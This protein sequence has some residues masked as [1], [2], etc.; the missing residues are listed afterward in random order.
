MEKNSTEAPFSSVNPRIKEIERGD[1]YALLAVCTDEELAP[2]VKAIT[3]K[4]SNSLELHEDYKRFA[5]RHTMYHRVIGDEIRLYG[6]NSFSNVF[7]GGEGPTYDEVV[8][9]VCKKLDIPFKPGE[10]VKNESKVLT[11]YLDRQWRALSRDEQE[12]IIAK[13]RTTASKQTINAQTIIKEGGTVLLTR[14]VSAPFALGTLAF[15]VADPAFT[16]TVPCVLHIAYLR[17]K[18]LDGVLACSDTPPEAASSA[19]KST[20]VAAMSRAAPIVIGFSANEPV[21]SLAQISEPAIQRW[22]PVDDSQEGISRL[23]PLLQ[24]APSLVTAGE[25][26]NTKY[27]E[28][29]INGPLL[30]AKG[31]DGFRNITMI[32]GKPSHGILLEP[33]KLSNIVNAAA[34]L[35]VASIAVAQK[36]L[37][38]ISE[39]LSEIKACVDRIHHF[40]K[41]ERRSVLTGSIRYFE[42]VAQSVLSGELSDGVRNQI[43]HHEAD[44]L[45]VHD[46]LMEDIRHETQEILNIKDSDM[47]GSKG[48]Q[49]AIEKHQKLLDDLYQQLLLCTR[50]R[51]C[52]WQLLVAFPGEESLKKNRKRSIQDSLDAL[53]ESGELLEEADIFMRKKV[54]SLSSIWNTAETINK[55]KLSLLKWN[56]KLVGNI[57]LCK[58]QILRDI[59]ATETMISDQRQPVTMIVKIEG[60]QIIGTCAALNIAEAYSPEELG[61][62]IRVVLGEMS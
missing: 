61:E 26:A 25:V 20:S 2:L 11:I 41:N 14:A 17:K 42:Q 40:Q 32:D 24:T 9:D 7:R 5:P 30:K 52:G 43:E 38:D 44:L 48:M 51:A 35:Q 3:S 55:R 56:D 36:H 59:R 1:L 54:K 39:K 19:G 58:E 23:N 13:A 53:S 16:V 18:F 34:L 37:A 6:G 31:Q 10:T 47:F 22:H 15:S 28:V 60:D 45:R 33:S 62:E 57:N 4:F 29:V 8:I 21:L 49:E 12:K 46:H 50:A 27:M